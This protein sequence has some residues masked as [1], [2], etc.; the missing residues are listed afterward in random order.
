MGDLFFYICLSDDL[1]DGQS[2]PINISWRREAAKVDKSPDAAITF[3]KYIYVAIPP[4]FTPPVDWAIGNGEALTVNQGKGGTSNI[5]TRITNDHIFIYAGKFS[6]RHPV[7]PNWW[8]IRI[9]AALIDSP[10]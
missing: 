6:L 9:T 3:S 4:E 10:R 5:E 8:F 1:G 2:G 7:A